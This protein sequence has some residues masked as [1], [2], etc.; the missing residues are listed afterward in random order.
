M[1]EHGIGAV[2]VGMTLAEA[3][4][5]AMG[6]LTAPPAADTAECGFATWK[7]GPAG[8]RFMTARGR[9]A[10]VDVSS[11]VVATAAGARV[12]DA[13]EKIAALYP[14]RVQVGPSKY[15]SGHTLTIKGGSPADSMYRLIFD[16]DGK[17]VT[18]LRAGRSPEVAFVEGC[19]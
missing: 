10:R 15:S 13:E 2:K 4:S 8:V 1:S 5:V 9:I 17:R 14:G 16:T 19:G 11:G 18:A 7:G 3:S 12:G 6:T